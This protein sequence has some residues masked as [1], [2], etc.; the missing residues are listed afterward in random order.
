MCTSRNLGGHLRILPT[1]VCDKV[2]NQTWLE[3]IKCDFSWDMRIREDR[4]SLW[5]CSLISSSLKKSHALIGDGRS[6]AYSSLGAWWCM[7]RLMCYVKTKASVDPLESRRPQSNL[8]YKIYGMM[9]L[10][11]PVYSMRYHRKMKWKNKI[12]YCNCL[13]KWNS[14]KAN[15]KILPSWVG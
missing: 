2:R 13:G 8:Q 14:P 15:G 3:I 5:A 6:K 4:H 1:T 12:M 7:K 11:F 10:G 9:C